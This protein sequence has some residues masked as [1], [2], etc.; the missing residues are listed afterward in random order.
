MGPL[1]K[2]ASDEEAAAIKKLFVRLRKFID[3]SEA[4]MFGADSADS[5]PPEVLEQYFVEFQKHKDVYSKRYKYLIARA[6]K[7]MGKSAILTHLAHTKAKYENVIVVSTTGAKLYEF[8]TPYAETESEATN[9]WYNIFAEAICSKICDTIESPKTNCEFAIVRRCSSFGARTGFIANIV[10]GITLKIPGLGFRDFSRVS[11][12]RILTEYLNE[13]T[14]K[15]VWLVI[16]D[17]D[18]AF[19]NDDRHITENSS[20]FNATRTLSN[21]FPNLYIR[22]CVRKDVWTTIRRKRESLDKCE[23]HMLD[24]EWSA[25]G[26]L[27]IIANRL[28]RFIREQAGEDLDILDLKRLDLIS[29][30]RIFLL[31]F[32]K[33]YPWHRNGSI[34][35]Y[36]FIQTF[37]GGRPRWA[38]QLCKMAAENVPSTSKQLKINSKNLSKSLASYSK[39]RVRDLY[40]EHQ[41]QCAQIESLMTAFATA[42]PRMS[43]NEIIQ[44]IHDKILSQI[45]VEIDGA[46]KCNE[47]QVASFLFRTGFLEAVV[48]TKNARSEPKILRFD[49]APHFSILFHPTI[50]LLIGRSIL[51]FE[52]VL[53]RRVE[54]CIISLIPT[55]LN[56]QII[57]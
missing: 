25:K 42:K 47:I 19:V 21:D 16:D 13:N 30:E 18:A 54:G 53:F 51:R 7:G 40:I 17:I 27:S 24:L 46:K 38:L 6:K 39:Y 57:Q 31:A 49:D 45:E 4:D 26:T 15:C 28:R 43:T 3:I 23:D 50:L 37:S 1:V 2:H 41:H 55:T 36:R 48:K 34:Q 52:V 56:L 29:D 9:I 20:F 10:S 14:D 35:T 5:E 32:Q 44:Y 22:T 11:F 33:T 12:Y 8:G